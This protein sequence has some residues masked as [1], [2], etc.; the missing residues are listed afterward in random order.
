MGPLRARTQTKPHGE[1]RHLDAFHVESTKFISLAARCINLCYE[2]LSPQPTLCALRTSTTAPTTRPQ[3]MASPL[4][5]FAPSFGTKIAQAA[6]P[7]LLAT[8][9][10]LAG[11]AR[12]DPAR[13]ESP[14][15]A[16]VGVT[17]DDE[18]LGELVDLAA[19]LGDELHVRGRA[20][21]GLTEAAAAL[22]R[23]YSTPVRPANPEDLALLAREAEGAIKALSSGHTRE[24]LTRVE[25]V[26]TLVD[27][28][29][30]DSFG[31]D[32]SAKRAIFRACAAGIEAHL[33]NDN[34]SGAQQLSTWCLS[35]FPGLDFT[36]AQVSRTPK[37][38][39]K[40]DAL[41]VDAS[42]P[43]QEVRTALVDAAAT[44][45]SASRTPLVID[46]DPPDCAVF[47][48]GQRVGRTPYTLEHP[49]RRTYAV[50]VECDLASRVHLVKPGDRNR[51]FVDLRF[52][53]A[54][55][56]SGGLVRLRYAQ[57]NDAMSR[58]HALRIGA[59]LHAQEVLLVEAR[60]AGRLTLRRLKDG[61]STDL[62]LP[63]TR[64][65][66]RKALGVVFHRDAP[67]VPPDAPPPRPGSRESLPE[68]LVETERDLT[69]EDETTPAPE[70][71][72]AEHSPQ[73]WRLWAGVP[74]VTAGLG[75]TV[76]AG[77]LLRERVHAGGRYQLA[78]PL[79]D[80]Y[81]SRQHDW[82]RR[83]RPLY[84]ASITG[85]ALASVGAG[86][87]AGQFAPDRNI[88]LPI[89]SSA[90][91]LTG[92][93]V[94]GLQ[95]ARWEHCSSLKPGQS[96]QTCVLNQAHRDRGAVVLL[97]TTPLVVFSSA[98]LVRWLLPGFDANLAADASK[99][100]FRLT[101]SGRF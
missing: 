31:R 80:D 85:A 48:Q 15:I 84:A 90:L 93:I 24:A 19:S 46:S 101:L 13:A 97:A 5:P 34:S 8:L 6:P 74:L 95:V 91:A 100:R 36:P 9:F 40:R 71:A 73:T 56:T 66:V 63:Y 55:Q 60:G 18:R 44:L 10:A 4:L 14:D 11:A 28:G 3:N 96:L 38:P 50:V 59:Q 2:I 57:P 61:T 70:A 82:A 33:R 49:V 67:G 23:D 17:R 65:D 78:R 16:I 41:R 27:A 21:I 68:P 29:G 42:L 79:S 58:D 83:G 7:L 22:E 72:H 98:W 76:V 35:V 81:L 1:Q 32:A 77:V 20:S 94:G 87:L 26:Q 54:L 37:E 88:W 45:K 12:P 64:D 43:S 51:M 25:R 89:A 99:D 75:A 39:T 30:M 69:E 86:L 47:L 62:G 53:A 92:I 52:D